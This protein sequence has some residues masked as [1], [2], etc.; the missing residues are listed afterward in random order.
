MKTLA[1]L[2]AALAVALVAAA[3]ANAQVNYGCGYHDDTNCTPPGCPTGKVCAMAHVYETGPSHCPG[4]PR[5]E[6]KD[7]GAAPAGCAKLLFPASPGDRATLS[8]IG[9]VDPIP[10]PGWEEPPPPVDLARGI[11]WACYFEC[12]DPWECSTVGCPAF[13]EECP[14]P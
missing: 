14:C 12:I 5:Q 4:Y 2:G 10:T 13:Y 6:P 7:S 11:C 8:P 9:S 3:A 1:S